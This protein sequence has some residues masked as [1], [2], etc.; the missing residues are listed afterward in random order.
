VPV[1]TRTCI[2]D[3]KDAAKICTAACKEEFQVAKDDCRDLD[4][5]CVELCRA[6]RTTCREQVRTTTLNPALAICEANKEEGIHGTADDGDPSCDQQYPEPRD[7]QA[8]ID[9]DQCVDEQVVAFFCRDEAH[10]AARPGYVLP[11]RL[12]RLRGPGL[13]HHS[14][15]LNEV[16]ETKP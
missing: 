15:T 6:E 14:C 1:D 9:Y 7:A 3:A 8:L 13:P 12:S 2:H 4:H 16:T 5:D 10:E 11:S